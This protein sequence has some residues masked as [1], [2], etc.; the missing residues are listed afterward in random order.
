MVAGT[1]L[2]SMQVYELLR[3]LEFLRSLPNVDAS[4]ISITGKA[5]MGVN[6]M[7]AALLDGKVHRVVLH[8]PTDSH[9]NGPH[10]LGILRYTDV[11]EVVKLTEARIYGDASLGIVSCGGLAECLDK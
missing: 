9:R 11:P 2:E 10:Y 1:T 3:G 4:R 8:S 7:Y 5:E 6:A